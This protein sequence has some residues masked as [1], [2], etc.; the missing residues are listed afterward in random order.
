VT[1]EEYNWDV[2][3]GYGTRQVPVDRID[4]FIHIKE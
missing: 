4:N 2:R 3:H 1:V